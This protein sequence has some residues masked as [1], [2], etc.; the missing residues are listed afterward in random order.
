MAYNELIKNFEKIR[1]YMRDFYVYGFKSRSDFDYKSMRAYDDE[2][3]RIESWLGDYMSFTYKD[4]K[5][6][7]LS[8]DSRTVQSNPLYK[9]WK[10]KSFTDGDVVLHFIIFDI[11]YDWKIKKTL[12]EIITEVDELLELEIT[13]DE[14]TIRKKLKEYANE[15]I[16]NIEKHG[17]KV[18]YSRSHDFDISHMRSMIDF[19]SE[20]MP[21]G[22]IGSFLQ[23]RLP[24]HNN[25]FFFKHHY[26]T[27]ALDSGVLLDLFLAIKKKTF[28]EVDNLGRR[29]DKA[30]T[31]R[32]VPL[33]IY[34]SSQ[35][36]RQYLI[37]YHEKAQLMNA[38]RLDY[39]SN[40]REKEECS[41]YQELKSILINNE[42]YMWGVNSH[43]NFDN[44]E[45]VE[46]TIKIAKNES[47]VL[48]R[49]EREKRC[50]FV[51]KI[52]NNHYQ[53]SA[54]LFDLLEIIPWIRTFISYIENIH[55]SNKRIEK[56]F[57]SDLEEM[58]RMYDIDKGDVL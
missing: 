44:T 43:I 18:L 46:F 20:I 31:I 6:A 2:K 24:Y 57:L 56:K 27:S 17:K 28:I 54:L 4:E 32:L 48:K 30:K 1:K 23:D 36:G 13:F 58:Y 51:K 26:I 33:K 7:Y 47:Y 25:Y 19:S 49:L 8:V 11:L 40:V 50:G 39:L 16:I 34:I 22:V 3:R 42:Q 29:F 53:Y 5:F 37:A 55:F 52:D 35:N 9:A 12:N 10:T 45:Y 21:C 14:S 41:F 15:G 38:Y